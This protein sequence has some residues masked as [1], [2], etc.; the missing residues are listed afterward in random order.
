MWGKKEE[1]RKKDHRYEE[2]KHI[3]RVDD[4]SQNDYSIK[5]VL[6]KTRL[7]EYI[8]Y[9][10]REGNVVTVFFIIYSLVYVWN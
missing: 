2:E 8:N 6:S 7:R 10:D 4:Y 9:I 3:I 5:G 1:R